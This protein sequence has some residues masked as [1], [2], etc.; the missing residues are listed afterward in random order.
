MTAHFLKIIVSEPADAMGCPGGSVSFVVEVEPS[1]AEAATYQWRR[2]GTAV[3]GPGYVGATDAELIVGPLEPAL[4]GSYDCVVTHACGVATSLAATLALGGD[5]TI[6]QNLAAE[7]AVCRGQTVALTIAATGVGLGYQWEYAADS[8]FVP[9]ENGAGIGGATSATLTIANVQPESAGRYRCVVTGSCGADATSAESLLSVGDAPAV[10]STSSDATLC[11]GETFAADIVAT[12]ANLVYGWWF[13]DG[14]AYRALAASEPGVSGVD[15]PTLTITNVAAVHT[16]TY[17]CIVTGSCPISAQSSAIQLTVRPA[18]HVFTGASSLTRCEGQSAQFNVSATGTTIT[19]QWQFDGGSGFVDITGQLPGV[20]GASSAAFSISPVAVVHAGSYRCV[21]TGACGGSITTDAAT[22][23]VPIV[24]ALTNP[25]LPMDYSSC[26]GGQAVFE[27]AASGE[28][29]TY[30]WQAH[31]G[32]AFQNLVD[33]PGVS[34]AR[35]PV[36]VLTGALQANAGRYQCVVVGACGPALTSREAVLTITNEVCD[37]NGN[38]AEDSVDIASAFSDDC[39]A[40]GI[41]DECEIASGSSAPGGPFFCTAGCLADCNAN[42]RPD[43]CDI[44]DGAVSDCN[45]N[46]VPDECETGGSAADCNANGIPDA[47]DIAGGA[48]ED[49]NRNG[50]PDECEAPYVVDAGTDVS[51]CSGQATVTLGGAVAASGSS[52]PYTYSWQIVSG[53]GGGALLNATAAHPVLNA[54]QAGTYIVRLTVSDSTVPPCVRT[55]EVAVSVYSMTVDAGPNMSVGAGGT[56]APLSAMAMGG[57]GEVTYEWHVEAGSPST[58]ASQFTGGGANSRTPTFTPALPGR[59]TRVTARDANTPTACSVSDTMV[60]DSVLMTISAP[61]DFAMCVS[62]ESSPLTVAITSPGIPPYSYAWSIEAGSANSAMGQF[63]GDGPLSSRPTFVPDAIGDYVLRVTVR[64]SSVPPSEVSR[65]I[66]VTAGGMQ[67][68]LPSEISQCAGPVGVRLPRPAVSGG[69]GTV[70]YNWTILP[71]APS[72]EP[73]Q[74]SDHSAFDAGWL[75]TP[76]APGNYTLQLTATDSGT[77]ACVRSSQ[78]VLRATTLSIDAGAD[79]VTKAFEGSKPLGRLS[80]VAGGGPNLSYRW[81][82]LAGPSIDKKQFSDSKAERP[83]FKPGDVGTYALQVTATDEDADSCSISDVI[84][85]ESIIASRTMAANGEGRVFLSLRID[86]PY[87]AAEIR[88]A[89][90]VP[91]M[92]FSG[93][94]TDESE[95]AD[96]TGLVDD[97]KMNRRVK[98]TTNANSGEF[99]AVVA[100][101]YENSEISSNADASIRIHQWDESDRT[102]RPTTAARQEQ[103]I[104]PSRPITSD[105]GRAG[106][107]AMPAIGENVFMSWAVID[108]GGKFSAGVSAANATPMTSD[109]PGGSPAPGGNGSVDDLMGSLC[110]ASG[111]GAGLISMLFAPAMAIRCLRRRGRRTGRRAHNG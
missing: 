14:G 79:F 42:G 16:G 95:A 28:A 74:F 94:L 13:S 40:N 81:Q 103:G 99:V 24:T 77:P 6:V 5:T 39:N 49:C 8:S 19:Y 7:T 67:I 100:V 97:A 35:A 55:D 63:G 59:Y 107:V 25:A 45:S 68:T 18:T 102:W 75:F 104:Y 34:G 109:S 41:P 86:K 11:E 82:V 93:E 4:V 83:T 88:V 21:V 85:V 111:G 33:G 72:N 108:G 56:S 17:R 20:T 105:V 48:S 27:V 87:Q 52:P 70:T 37:C 65:T 2:N 89:S 73:T 71:G 3:S 96:R 54:S 12:G 57:S 50:V 32:A 43:S 15:G 38:G 47:C 64:D 62:G 26:P 30:Q 53:P 98:L 36:L 92:E 46:N 101:F 51:V 10:S 69:A 31:V 76:A 29:M 90:A 110:G 91:G 22:L 66:A 9:V 61:A 1:L 80:M 60:L 106:A 58:A 23:H 84:V 78:L 44:A